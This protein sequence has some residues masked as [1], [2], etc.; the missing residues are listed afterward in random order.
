MENLSDRFSRVHFPHSAQ[1][2]NVCFT[3][4]KLKFRIPPKK[5]TRAAETL[6]WHVCTDLHLKVRPESVCVVVTV[7]RSSV[8]NL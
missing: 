1:N 6:D 4:G 8:S 2:K 7:R 5:N 3:A